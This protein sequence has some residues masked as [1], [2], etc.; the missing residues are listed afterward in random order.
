VRFGDNAIVVFVLIHRP[1]DAEFARSGEQ[2]HMNDKPLRWLFDLKREGDLN[3][4]MDGF[5]CRVEF[6]QRHRF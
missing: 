2:A 6:F 3:R 4:W 1:E 5:N